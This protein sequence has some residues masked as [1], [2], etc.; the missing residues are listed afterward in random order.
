MGRRSPTA[1]TPVPEHIVT[2]L[3][4]LLTDEFDRL[5]ATAKTDKTKAE[6]QRAQLLDER[7]TL[8]K[9]HYAGAV[10]LDL[11][12]EEQERIQRQ[13]DLLT[14]QIEATKDIYDAA[15]A[16]LDDLLELAHNAYDLYTSLDP[17]N[18]GCIP[19][20]VG[21]GSGGLSFSVVLRRVDAPV[22]G[23]CE[24]VQGWLPPHRPSHFPPTRRVERPCHQIQAF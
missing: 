10:P 14:S 3:R 12:K 7:K 4:H 19:L 21:W 15:K 17:A 20:T 13:L 22:E 6:H 24:S 23:D 5:Y 8:L 11:L 16:H 9:A 2:A 1:S 18:K